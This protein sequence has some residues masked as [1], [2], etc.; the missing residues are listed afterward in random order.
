[1][2]I[3]VASVLGIYGVAICWLLLI[4]HLSSM[5][6]INSPY[7]AP[8]A[9]FKGSDLKDSFIRFPLRNMFKRP[10]SLE[11][12]DVVKQKKSGGTI[13]GKDKK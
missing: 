6:S 1:M 4:I 8:V 7:L 9:P 2:I 10:V 11:P 3:F 5:E 12:K 13:N